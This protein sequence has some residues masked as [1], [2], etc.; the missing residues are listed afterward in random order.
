MA[1]EV[2]KVTPT[3]KARRSDSLYFDNVKRRLLCDMVANLEADRDDL[4]GLIR[5][6]LMTINNAQR[7]FSTHPK[8]YRD[9]YSRAK[10]LGVDLS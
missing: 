10:K 5:D 8:T 2:W 7:G 6:A 4:H 3:E 9:Y 1:E